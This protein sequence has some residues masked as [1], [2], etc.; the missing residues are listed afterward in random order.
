[1]TNGRLRNNEEN[2]NQMEQH[3]TT[4]DFRNVVYEITYKSDVFVQNEEKK[5]TNQ[6][7]RKLLTLT[8]HYEYGN[9]FQMKLVTTVRV[10][11]FLTF[12]RHYKMICLGFFF[13]HF[14]A[15]SIIRKIPM[16]AISLVLSAK[17]QRNIYFLF[18]WLFFSLSLCV[19]IA[20]T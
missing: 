14:D 11:V 4:F 10:N 15:N 20:M 7:S 12:M 1:M 2:K 5:K 3:K 6:I 13:F 17:T 18:T 8:L 19:H 9:I 16:I